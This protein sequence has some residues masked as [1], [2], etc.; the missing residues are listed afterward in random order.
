VGEPAPGAS[1]DLTL[2]GKFRI[3]NRDFSGAEEVLNR[4]MQCL[5]QVGGEEN[6][7]GAVTLYQLAKLYG[8]THRQQQAETL[9]K[10]A[11]RIDER[12]WPAELLA[13]LKD[14]AGFLRAM[15]RKQEAKRVEADLR[16]RAKAL[17]Q[18]SPSGQ[19]VDV[20]TLLREGNHQ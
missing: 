10:H 5:R 16:V 3:L 19:I 20:R 14:Y 17:F 6:V 15:K 2:V 1:D 4:S 9:F 12:L 18:D 13:V 7:V 11:I 8:A